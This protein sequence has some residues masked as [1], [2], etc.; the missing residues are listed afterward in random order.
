MKFS[1]ENIGEIFIIEKGTVQSSKNI[2]GSYDFI[3]AGAEWKTHNEFSHDCEALIFAMGASGSLGRT[4]YANGKFIASDLCFILTPKIQYRERVDLKF[5]YS[6]FN[7]IRNE[8]VKQTATG[9]SKMAINAKNF[10][11][12]KIVFPSIEEQKQARFS[13]ER[14]QPKSALLS[15]VVEE[16]LNDISNLRQSILQNAVQGKLVPQDPNDEPASVLLKKIKAEKEQMI[17]EKKI[18]K[19]KPLPEITEDMVPFDLPQGWKW[20]KFQDILFQIKYGTS[21]KCEYET[22]NTPVLRIPNIKNGKID[23]TDLKYADFTETELEE[24]SLEVDDLLM[25]RSNGSS[26]LVGR[27]AHILS[28]AKGF[29]YA[30]YLVRLRIAKSFININYLLLVF[31]SNFIREQIE[32]PI[33]TTSGVKNINTSE[34]SRLI[35]PIPP[36][37]EQKRIVEKVDKLMLLCDELEKTVEQ[38]RCD[39]EMLMQS[40]LPEAFSQSEKEDNVVALPSANTNAIEDWE[41][42]ARSDGGIN[43]ETKV[44][45]KNRVTELIGKSQQ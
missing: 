19:E 43:S 44:K 6:Y 10:S 28:T 30:G 29:T 40:V 5:Y 35:L 20:V 45:I 39:S 38:S 34:I 18:K 41:I 16:C 22:G 11:N 33:R 14:I 2:P 17:K 31:N 1:Y 13:L 26:T 42:A 36:L 8:I 4:H 25:V 27:I 15:E 7:S 37:Q 9:T 3:T 23:F 21:K 24:L 12:Y 32:M